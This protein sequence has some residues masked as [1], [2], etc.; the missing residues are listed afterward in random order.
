MK[1]VS[2][3]A[4]LAMDNKTIVKKSTREAD[5]GTDSSGEPD[6]ISEGLATGIVVNTFLILFIVGGNILVIAAYVKNHRLRTGTYALLVS[7]ALSDLLVGGIA[8]P[9]RIYG[10]IKSWDVSVI[11]VLVYTAFDIFSAVVSN[12]HLMAISFERFIAVSRPFYHQTLSVSPYAVASMMSWTFGVVVASVHPGNYLQNVSDI[13]LKLRLLK[14]YSVTLFT[15]SFLGP[16]TMIT[17]V[18]IGIFRIAR[19]L[20]RRDPL[21]HGN[22]GQRRLKKERKAALTLVVMTGFFFIAWFPFFVVNMLYLYCFTC[23]PSSIKAQF[24]MVDIIKWLHYSNSAINPAI[25]AYRDVEMRRT[26]ARLLV[27][28][29]KFCGLNQVEPEQTN[30]Q[31]VIDMQTR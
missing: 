6:L 23:L 24:V 2:T 27:P 9:I 15:L 14:V 18:N 5:N 21:Q 1:N 20:I 31:V 8:I 13:S 28:L 29:G 16:L 7:L 19:V 12:L 17:I 30:T 3:R 25:Y 22:L 11:F 26:F 10:S 4:S